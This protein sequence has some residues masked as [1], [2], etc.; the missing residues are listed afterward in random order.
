MRP[1]ILYVGGVCSNG[2]TLTKINCRLQGTKWRCIDCEAEYRKKR[3]YG[4]CNERT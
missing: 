4:R 3:Q 2:H 1:R